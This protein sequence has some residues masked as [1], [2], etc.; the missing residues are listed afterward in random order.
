[1]L[2]AMPPNLCTHPQPVNRNAHLL[3][4]QQHRNKHPA[5]LWR[6]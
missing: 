4:Q 6:S 3:A 2:V 1:M 5:L